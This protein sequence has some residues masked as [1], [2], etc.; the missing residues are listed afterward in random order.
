M[1]SVCERII[2]FS[3]DNSSAVVETEEAA[4]APP[5]L[6]LEAAAAGLLKSSKT[7]TG[8]TITDRRQGTLSHRANAV[9]KMEVGGQKKRG[10]ARGS[11]K[12]KPKT[13]QAKFVRLTACSC[14]QT[15]LGSWTQVG[16]PSGQGAFIS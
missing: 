8:N 5:S 13:K 11:G 15:R 4:T 7:K 16:A 6:T 1:I 14:R 12:I 3:I 10:D 9:Q 2:D